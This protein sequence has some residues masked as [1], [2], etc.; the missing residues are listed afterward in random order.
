MRA[1]VDAEDG[2]TFSDLNLEFHRTIVPSCG[3]DMLRDPTMDIWQRHSGF[4]RVS[5]MVPARLAISVGDEARPVPP[6][7]APAAP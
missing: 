2:P 7:H 3:N 4:Q 1:A 6:D 5:R